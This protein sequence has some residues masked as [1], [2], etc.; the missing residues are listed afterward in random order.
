MIAPAAPRTSRASAGV[1]EQFKAT[2]QDEII[3]AIHAGEID[4][5]SRGATGIQAER[6]ARMR[7]YL[8]AGTPER[9]RARESACVCYGSATVDS[10]PGTLEHRTTEEGYR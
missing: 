4:R 10:R 9:V 7:S 2:R 8:G 1:W 3:P 5:A 6:L